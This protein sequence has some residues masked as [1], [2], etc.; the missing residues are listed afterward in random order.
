MNAK[1]EKEANRLAEMLLA[2]YRRWNS[3]DISHK[4][5]LKNQ[6]R[7]SDMVVAANVWDEIA[8]RGFYL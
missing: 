5:Y 1:K 4:E 8:A 2:N 7:I 6:A 3:G